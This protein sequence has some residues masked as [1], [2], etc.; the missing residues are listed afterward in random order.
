M[1][2]NSQPKKENTIKYPTLL[3]SLRKIN[4]ARLKGLSKKKPID[5]IQIK[6][7]QKVKDLKSRYKSKKSNV[8]YYTRKKKGIMKKLRNRKKIKKIKSKS[9]IFVY[10]FNFLI[11]KTILKYI[12]N[13]FVIKSTI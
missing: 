7:I 8:Y 10:F 5:K 6:K 1:E 11:R 9:T 3:R 12:S 2:K 4:R 13:S